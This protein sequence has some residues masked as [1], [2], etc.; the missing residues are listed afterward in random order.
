V[1]TATVK[2]RR[3]SS[4]SP[5]GRS[6]GAKQPQ[7]SS[8]TNKGRQGGGNR[9]STARP[10]GSRARARPATPK[11]AGRAR[12][13]PAAKQGLELASAAKRS[14][15]PSKLKTLS[16]A[17]RAARVGLRLARGKR[18]KPK[19]LRKAASTATEVGVEALAAKARNLPLQQVAEL[20]RRIP[21][22][23][24]PENI[25]KLPVQRSID[26]AVPLQVA[27]DEWM[28]L[29]ALP[30]GAHRVV[31]I[32]R[33]SDRLVGQL[34]GMGKPQPWEAEIRD[35]RPNESF[36]WRSTR[37]SDVAGLITFHR[38]SE[39]LTRLELELDVVPTSPGE[40]AS[41]ALHVADR[42]AETELRQFKSRVETISPDAYPTPAKATNRKSPKSSAT[43]R[44]S[45]KSSKNKEE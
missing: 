37:G 2:P 41:L 45:P 44:K 16:L 15:G 29:D 39:R 20:L 33:R 11:A 38:L 6:Q 3:R 26:V 28:R 40:A 30:E 19:Q 32:D 43:N 7:G 22:Q 5:N 34:N 18:P 8:R 4:P 12:P 1:A 27:Y 13:A 25:R 9:A 36:A 24:L 14:G 35:E 17:W 42:R 31:E 10:G 21:A 23:Q